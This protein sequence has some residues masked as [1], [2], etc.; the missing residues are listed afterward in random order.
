MKPPGVSFFCGTLRRPGKQS[1]KRHKLPIWGEF[2][3]RL[4]GGGSTK[5]KSGLDT[6]R[7]A[8]R[9]PMHV[10]RLRRGG[11]AYRK[12]WLRAYRE[13]TDSPEQRSSA[14]ARDFSMWFTQ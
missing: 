2:A 9:V 5:S 3:S 14:C 11:V 10:W 1:T 8:K 4:T 6:H 13:A 12:A 7:V